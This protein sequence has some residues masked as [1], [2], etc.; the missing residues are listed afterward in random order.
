M[1]RIDHE[2][3]IQIIPEA[4]V[5]RNRGAMHGKMLQERSESS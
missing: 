1:T 3:D 2:T 4:V 5:S